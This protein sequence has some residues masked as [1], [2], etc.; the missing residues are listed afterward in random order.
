MAEIP[1]ARVRRLENAELPR[2]IQGRLKNGSGHA[3]KSNIMPR[4]ESANAG[5]RTTREG[6]LQPGKLGGRASS[7]ANPPLFS[8]Q[9]AKSAKNP[10]PVFLRE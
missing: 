3:G 6:G 5:I 7:P 4:R 1:Q 8:R 2:R 10:F 9:V